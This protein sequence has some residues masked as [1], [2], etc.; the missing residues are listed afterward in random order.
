MIKVILLFIFE[1][2]FWS[3]LFIITFILAGSMMIIWFAD[4]IT[5]KGIGNGI[6]IIVLVDCVG[7]VSN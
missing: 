6:S 4:Q 1:K 7:V 5:E 2:L 3:Y